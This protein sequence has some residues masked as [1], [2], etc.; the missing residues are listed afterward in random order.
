MMT[1]NDK[2]AR[3]EAALPNG[4]TAYVRRTKAGLFR[5]GRLVKMRYGWAHQYLA[6]CD[7]GELAEA[8]AMNDAAFEGALL[9]RSFPGSNSECW[10]QGAHTPDG[11]RL[12]AT[13]TGGGAGHRL[14]VL[15]SGG[16]AH[17]DLS[18]SALRRIAQQFYTN[19][20]VR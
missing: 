1:Y 17:Y 3:W 10:A 19:P 8:A 13:L 7:T 12:V 15:P 5:P 20:E 14:L 6:D 4:D 2:R 18:A 9:W 16:V 11:H